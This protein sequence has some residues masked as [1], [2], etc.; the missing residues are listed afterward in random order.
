MDAENTVKFL[1]G[2][3]VYFRHF[4]VRYRS[5]RM[6]IVNVYDTVSKLLTYALEYMRADV[7]SE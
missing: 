3:R 7:T 6:A 5:C 2:G 4:H 1:G